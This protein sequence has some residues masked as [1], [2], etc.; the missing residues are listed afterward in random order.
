M[1]RDKFTIVLGYRGWYDIV[2]RPGVAAAENELR[3]G[4]TNTPPTEW[5]AL[6]ARD[7]VEFVLGQ[8]IVC[9]EVN[10]AAHEFDHDEILLAVEGCR[11]GQKREML[12]KLF[13]ML[14]STYI[15]L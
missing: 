3:A 5:P 14:S 6:D 8:N 2:E 4:I 15:W 1:S 12:T 11:L 7:L 10:A 13:H 9:G